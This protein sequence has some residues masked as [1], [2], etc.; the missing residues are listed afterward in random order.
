MRTIEIITD[1]KAPPVA[2]RHLD[3]SDHSRAIGLL[4]SIG[5]KLQIFRSG[6][7]CPSD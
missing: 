6:F 2:S 3:G 5:K 7:F 4:A 1:I